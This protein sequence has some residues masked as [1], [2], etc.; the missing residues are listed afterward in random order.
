[1]TRPHPETQTARTVDLLENTDVHG[2]EPAAPKR[3]LLTVRTATHDSQPV[4]VPLG[5]Y[6]ARRLTGRPVNPALSSTPVQRS[7]YKE[8]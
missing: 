6:L 7:I 1:M 2:F 5:H 3:R 4:T 8:R